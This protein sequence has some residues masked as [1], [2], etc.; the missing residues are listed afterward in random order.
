M[1][2]RA[3]AVSGAL[4][5][6]GSSA[7]SGVPFRK[8]KMNKLPRS[9]A[10]VAA[11]FLSVALL[12]ADGRRMT[13]DERVEARRAIEEV[14]YAHQIGATEP[15]DQAVPRAVLEDKV[16][17]YLKETVALRRF[18]GTEITASALQ[19]ELERMA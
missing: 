15:F 17:A 16:R 13:V 11:G 2:N 10:V 3:P 6:P 9:I 12:G 8:G 7:R 18:W 5:L 19:E 1:R 14:Y 4:F